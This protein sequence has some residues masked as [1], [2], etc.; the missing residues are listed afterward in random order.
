[1]NFGNFN[2]I[3]QFVHSNFYSTYGCWELSTKKPQ[4]CTAPKKLDIIW[5]Y[6][7]GKKSQV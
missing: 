6:F 7:Y 4:N 1:M 2:A 5:G 3:F